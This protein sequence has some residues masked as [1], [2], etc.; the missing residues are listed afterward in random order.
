MKKIFNITLI[1]LILLTLIIS[2]NGLAEETNLK[3]EETNMVEN[4]ELLG[5]AKVFTKNKGSLNMRAENKPKGKIVKK[6]PNGSVL[7]TIEV[8]EEWTKAVY[9]DEIGFVKSEFLEFMGAEGT[10]SP[11]TNKEKGNQV[12]EIKN[13]LYQLGYL[14][15]EDINQQFD[16]KMEIALT[17]LQ[18][19]NE[20]ALNPTVVSS[21]L[22]SL[23]EW[24]M[25]EK[26]KSG[27]TDVVTDEETGL[28]VG[29]FC[30][31][32]GGT[33]YEADQAVKVKI[34]YAVQ[35]TGGT[36]PYQITVKKSLTEEKYGDEVKTPFSYIWKKT[37]EH[38]YVYATAVDANGN[39]VTAKANFK[40]T[41]PERYQ[42]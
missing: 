28:T 40:F 4:T 35:A 24:G 41:L 5:Y 17:K 37:T 22:Q 33:L 10:Y 3:T 20:V 31:D 6:I 29:I 42:D 14:K 27:Y 13:K 2:I 30:W 23:L 15:K 34:N 21:E 39:T 32:S 19:M 36:A 25:I 11:I 16:K 9:K 26:G 1:C 12:L 38:L 18:L 8:G 7:R